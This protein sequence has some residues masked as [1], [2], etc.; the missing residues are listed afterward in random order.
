MPNEFCQLPDTHPVAAQ[1]LLWLV[2]PI[3]DGANL[4]QGSPGDAPTPPRVFCQG[5]QGGGSAGEWRQV[6]AG[7]H[8]SAAEQ[9]WAGVRGAA[10]RGDTQPSFP[11]PLGALLL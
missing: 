6:R 5:V 8:G 10:G 1:A 3:P 9:S 2:T 4:N 11:A 7:T